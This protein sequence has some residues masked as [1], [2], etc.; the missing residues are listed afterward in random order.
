MT[1]FLRKLGKDWVKEKQIWGR[2]EL[3][4]IPGD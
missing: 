3:W 1:Q 4:N 2:T